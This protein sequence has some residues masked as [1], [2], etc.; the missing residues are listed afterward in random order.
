MTR[1]ESVSTAVV[2]AN[3]DWTI[4]RIAND[5]GRVGWGECFFA[6]G[7]TETVAQLGELLVGHDARQVQPLMN[8]LRTAASGAGSTGGIV[9]NA[10]SGIDAALWDLAA[11]TLDV[12]L[13]QLLGGRFRET[14]RLYADC[15]ADTDLSSLGPLLQFRPAR[16]ADQQASDPDG[17]V[18]TLFDPDEGD[19]APVDL[20]AM[21]ERAR[22]VAA[23]GFDALKFDV[24]VP[25]LLPRHA[26]SRHLPPQSIVLVE[27]MID[28]VR[29]GAGEQVDLALDCH[30]R[31]D[32]ATAILIAERCAAKGILWLED[33]IP[34]DNVAAVASL[35]RRCPVP[36][37][38]GENLYY[39]TAFEPLLAAGALAVATPDFQK[40]GGVQ[41]AQTISRIAERHG[42]SI[43]PHNISGPVGTAFSAHL[44]STMPGFLALEF[45]AFDV[46]FFNDL[47]DHPV[48]EDGAVRLT[49]RPGIGVTV[50]LDAVRQWSK[51]D[52]PVFGEKPWIATR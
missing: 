18:V 21:T 48:V 41:E 51:R 23:H 11:R 3:F 24:D 8:R 2:E 4:V 40:F 6:P 44:G 22:V 13:W 46:P 52:E 32:V 39:W 12:P 25:G 19:A 27:A 28:A 38:G 36:L 49:E 43:A 45:H 1:I 9:V 15:H 33:P 16:W 14:V 37:G 30:W 10:L 31:Y 50:E 7:L 47:V 17:E 35:A 34:M 26:G 5:E 42:A 20:A 29:E